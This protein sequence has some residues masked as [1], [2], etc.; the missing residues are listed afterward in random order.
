MSKWEYDL[1]TMG[2]NLRDYINE[3]DS[4]KEH[5]ETILD[6]IICCCNYLLEN[7][8]NDDRNWYEI[9]LEELIQDCD[10]TRYYLD[11]D[12]YE[13]NEDNI[14]D[15]LTTFYNLMDSMRVWVAF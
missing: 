14:N 4:S 3:G 11:E 13:S 2:K 5:C 6:Q 1:K 9:D 8:T 7:L 10:D 12:D 15:V